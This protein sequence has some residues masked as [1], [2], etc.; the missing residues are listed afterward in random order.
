METKGPELPKGFV[1]E[2]EK[3]R[4]ITEYEPTPYSPEEQFGRILGTVKGKPM[5]TR[6]ALERPFMEEY[7]TLYGVGKAIETLPRGVQEFGEEIVAGATLGLSRQAA[8]LGEYLSEKITGRPVPKKEVILPEYMKTV[9]EFAGAVAPISAAGKIIAEP[10]IKLAGKSRYLEPFA[11]MIGWG[12]A[13]TVYE[14]ASRMASEGELPSPEEMAKS[15]GMWAGIEAILGA[16]GWTGRLAIGI[17]SLAKTWGIPRQEVLKAVLAEAK[18]RKMPIARYAYAKAKVQKALGEKVPKAAEKLVNVVETLHEPFAKR[19]T[20]QNLIEQLKGEELIS[21]IKTFKDY[22]GKGIELEK[23]IKPKLE[24]PLFELRGKGVE[25]PMPPGYTREEGI[26]LG[27]GPAGELQ[28]LYEKA[29]RGFKNSVDAIEFGVRNKGKGEITNIL[30]EGEKVFGIQAARALEKKDFQVAANLGAKSQFYREAAEATEGKLTHKG[31][32]KGFEG[33]S[34]PRPV[35]DSV[36]LGFGPLSEL[37]RTYK[38]VVDRIKARQK[39]EPA[40]KGELPGLPPEQKSLSQK[41]VDVLPML[42]KLRGE[43]EA[44]YTKERAIRF[45]KA[46]EAG[47]EAGGG[48]KGYIAELKKLEGEMPKAVFEKIKDKFTQEDFDGLFRMVDKSQSI[49]WTQKLSVRN[50][51]MQLFEKGKPPIDSVIPLL[52]EVFGGKLTKALIE[53]KGLWERFKNAGLEIANIPRSIMASFDFS[54]G[55]RQ[56]IFMAPSHRKAFWKSWKGQFKEFGSEK[57]YKAA[58]E[59]VNQHPDFHLAS[60]SGVSFTNV[61]KIMAEREERFASSWAEIIPGVR[62]SSRAYT[63]FANKFRMDIFS[64]LVKDA[65]KQ[66]LNPRKNMEMLNGIAELVNSGTGRGSLGGLEKASLALNAFFFSPRLMASRIRLL[67]PVYY[68]RQD[69]FVRKE[70][71]KSLFRFAATATTV[72]TLAKSGGAEVET[73]LRSAD[74]GK[75]KIGK[76]RIDILGGFQQ[77]IRLAAQ[78]QSGEIVSSTTGKV[79]TLGEGYKPLTRLDILGRAIEYKEAPVFSFATTMLRGK[80]P[81]GED[82]EFGKEIGKRFVPMI[83]Q[84]IYDLATEQPELLPLAPLGAFGFGLQTYGPKRKGLIK[85]GRRERP[86]IER[87]ERKRITR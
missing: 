5:P 2:T 45:A 86:R 31:Y 77:Y 36:T 23:E 32:V 58:M 47:I 44:L 85:T 59:A 83:T 12:V 22:A 3:P 7:P 24:K 16:T 35:P 70:A 81:L 42:K 49:D 82:I 48:V 37:E 65:E 19:G 11:K 66:G 28:K 51:L 78:L 15:G 61:G 75:I 14:T 17:N 73:D 6:P 52:E 74:F 71:L 30:R 4:Q 55:F 63:G 57:A 53:Q 10:L 72:L 8:R 76:T 29:R 50:S 54:F 18:A 69:P 40:V 60:K 43:Q 34:K 26:T 27:F 84:D 62:A 13:G 79:L 68:I 25:P 64:S 9:A 41:F 20:Y 46:K 80:T 56:G 33:V 39:V 87:K 1:L 67:N 38:Q 21:K